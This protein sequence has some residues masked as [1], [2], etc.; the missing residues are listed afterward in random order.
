MI[1]FTA[2]ALM[3][4][5]SVYAQPESLE[6]DWFTRLVAEDVVELREP[7]GWFGSFAVDTFVAQDK[8][9][10]GT[11]VPRQQWSLTGGWQGNLNLSLAGKFSVW[12]RHDSLAWYEDELALDYDERENKFELGETYLSWQLNNQTS[13]KLGRQ[14]IG[15]GYAQGFRVLDSFSAIDYRIPGYGELSQLK[16]PQTALNLSYQ[17]G[18][19][20]HRG[21]YLI[22]QREDLTDN[23]GPFGQPHPQGKES[24]AADDNMLYAVSHQYQNLDW[25]WAVGKVFNPQV[26]T[27]DSR[28]FYQT[29][30][31]M[32]FALSF[33]TGAWRLFTEQRWF[34]GEDIV[35][36]T[37]GAIPIKGRTHLLG[38][39]YSGISQM[40]FQ[41]EA[42][43]QVIEEQEEDA[44]YFSGNYLALKDT[45]TLSWQHSEFVSLDAALDQI[46]FDYN[47]RDGWHVKGGVIIYQADDASPYRSLSVNDTS[48]LVLSYFW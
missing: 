12:W 15:L 43:R 34:S 3:F 36:E 33:V 22:E 28:S 40:T 21:M 41:L 37:P 31:T 27:T 4:S 16:L 30:K 1:R 11:R 7:T 17:A 14:K 48:Y 2:L 44:L 13:L 24:Y 32:G 20:S 23:D 39:T 29:E 46:S 38:L 26:I 9:A 8:Q 25:Q 35:S 19:W 10:M 45:L 5:S 47:W 18:S 42:Q 6:P